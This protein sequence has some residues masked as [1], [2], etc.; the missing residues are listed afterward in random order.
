MNNRLNLIQNWEGLA[1]EA[2]WSVASMAKRCGV[3]VRT[4]ERYFLQR[5]GRSPKEWI[6]EK[7]QQRALKLLLA[8]YSVKETANHLGYTYPSTFSREFAKYWRFTPTR[9]ML[10][11]VGLARTTVA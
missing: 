7:R 5:K 2:G 8:S 6:N 3:S 10:N 4:I 11:S 9:A 1:E